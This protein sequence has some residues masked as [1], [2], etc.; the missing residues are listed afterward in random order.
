MKSKQVEK[1]HPYM[2]IRTSAECHFT[3]LLSEYNPSPRISRAEISPDFNK[4]PALYIL[5][6]APLEV[7]MKSSQ[8]Y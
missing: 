3:R 8:S 7:A 5:N 4:H 1:W 6:I 2:C